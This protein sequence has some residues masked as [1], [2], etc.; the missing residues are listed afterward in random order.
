M[1]RYIVWCAMGF[2][3]GCGGAP[4]AEEAR[5]SRGV[6]EYSA[7]GQSACVSGYEASFIHLEACGSDALNATRCTTSPALAAGWKVV[8]SQ[9]IPDPPPE[10]DVLPPGDD[11]GVAS[12]EIPDPPPEDNK[13]VKAKEIPD[14]PPEKN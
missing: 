11:A 1:K 6:V 9:E 13:G 2:A 14:P 3:V 4:G 10:K 7:C 8:R 12:Q 5:I